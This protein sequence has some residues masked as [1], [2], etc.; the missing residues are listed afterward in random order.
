MLS[1][2]LVSFTLELSTIC[3]V[4]AM[5][6]FGSSNAGLMCR[7][8]VSLGLVSVFPESFPQEPSVIPIAAMRTN[9]FIIG[10]FIRRFNVQWSAA[11]NLSYMIPIFL[12][13]GNHWLHAVNSIACSSICVDLSSFVIMEVY[14]LNYFIESNKDPTYCESTI[15]GWFSD[16]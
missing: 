9:F 6:E 5:L 12:P 4:S 2:I 14:P 11:V 1:F 3:I 7:F 16:K 10:L 13:C 8:V 15:M